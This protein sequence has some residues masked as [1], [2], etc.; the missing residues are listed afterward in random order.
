MR[1]AL[2]SDAPQGNNPSGLIAALDVGTSK[3]CCLIAQVDG[4]GRPRVRGI[5][6]QESRG[7]RGGGIVDMDA[8]ES[9]IRATVEAAE[10]MAGENIREVLV[11]VSCGHPA[12][13]LIAYEVSIAGHEIGDADLRRVLNPAQ[14][15]RD[16][17]P[18]REIIHAIPVGYRIDGS[19]G[20]RDPRG[21]F[22]DRLG[23]NMHLIGTD[24]GALRNLTSC[25]RRCHLDLAGRVVS[26][27]AAALACLVDDERQLGATIID[28]GGGTTSIAVFFDG[29]LIHTDVIPIGGVHVTTDIARGLS[30]PIAH[31]ERMKTLYGSVLPSPSDDREIIKVPVV[32]E[33]DESEVSQVPRSMLVGIIRPRVEETFEMVRTR[34]EDAGFDKVAGRRLV[35]TGGASQLPGA[36]ELA[37]QILDK[38]AR[39][40]RP[41]PMDGLAE[42]ACSAPFAT[43]VGLVNYCVGGLAERPGRAYRPIEEPKGRIGRLGQWF[44]ENF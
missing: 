28:M 24:A 41:R 7:L 16:L 38:Q 14:A 4:D 19:R 37:G 6:H 11:N 21:M 1:S 31:A 2:R 12:S 32:G 26:P 35:L 44:R 40:G 33:D 29:E 15:M 30:T 22:G 5:G 3:I 34:L 39:P 25:V 13:K 36:V 20:V 17:T 42:A 27:Y 18:D 9:A 10:Q 23:V 8:A 43:A